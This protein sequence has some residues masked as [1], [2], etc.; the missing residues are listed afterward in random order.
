MSACS[1]N[2][3]G[4]TRT[5]EIGGVRVHPV[6]LGRAEYDRRLLGREARQP[7]AQHLSHVLGVVAEVDRV[8]H[9]CGHE[10]EAASGGKD[11][12]RGE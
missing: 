6:E 12:E 9:A 10:G 2:R 8:L 5:A 3:T 4:R 11:Q 7:L 1:R